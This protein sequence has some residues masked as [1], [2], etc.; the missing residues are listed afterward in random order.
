MHRV[1]MS[2]TQKLVLIM[3]VF[4]VI[5]VGLS[6]AV[7]LF[8][9]N[10]LVNE[11][12]DLR[13]Y[14]GAK[15][16]IKEVH[17]YE[18][19]VYSAARALSEDVVV[20]ELFTEHTDAAALR[21]RS[22]VQAYLRLA[23]VDFIRLYNVNGGVVYATD[24]GENGDDAEYHRQIT[25]YG[26]KGRVNTG[27]VYHQGRLELISAV[28]VMRGQQILGIV[29]TGYVLSK[30]FL[31]HLRNLSSFDI[32]I[33]FNSGTILSTLYNADHT[34]LSLPLSDTAKQQLYEFTPYTEETVE[35]KH[36]YRVRYYPLLGLNGMVEAV[37]GV[38]MDTDK[39]TAAN[40]QTVLFVL[41]LCAA[42]V[43]GALI[44]SVSATSAIMKPL[45]ELVIVG[46]KV[47]RGELSVFNGTMNHDEIGELAQSFNHMV[48]DLRNA[49]DDLEKA[50]KDVR[51][52]HLD[53]I[54]RLAIAAEFKDVSTAHHIRRISEYS[55]LIARFYGLS[56]EEVEL[57]KYAAP[58]HDIGKIGI[59]D[60]ILLKGT[61]LTSQEY[62]RMKKHTVFGSKIFC[63]AETPLLQAAEVIS[64]TH[65][66]RYDGTGYPQGLR[67][68]A[69]HI[70][71]RIVAVADVFDALTSERV[72][73]PAYSLQQALDIIQQENGKHFDPKVVDAFLAALD[74]ILS[75]KYQYGIDSIE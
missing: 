73:K 56:K 53:T 46:K 59:P 69:I 49:F 16:V 52:A 64:L 31:E 28:P 17:N 20:A 38:V 71:G 10:T 58:M 5:S 41:S 25:T 42:L 63:E 18:E 40:H 39:F 14:E 7:A 47:R 34:M 44:I 11:Q 26:L 51:R 67:G 70:F 1:K 45:H 68:E 8:K 19:A 9:F 21:M 43:V 24:T 13:M 61:K 48:D 23:K 4:I 60:D 36:S 66:E 74:D 3:T 22:T 62:E 75:V 37:L 12:I 35:A 27:V 65:H 55:A 29:T 15:V 33:H 72:Y 54:L 50:N 32:A 2:L 30:S 6:V 57:I